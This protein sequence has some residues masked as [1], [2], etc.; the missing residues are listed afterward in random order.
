M[1]AHAD[2]LTVRYRPVLQA[3]WF[4]IYVGWVVV[5]FFVPDW[6]IKLLCLGVQTTGYVMI[7]KEFISQ[8]PILRVTVSKSRV[9]FWVLSW[10]GIQQTETQIGA[11][12]F[13]EEF[14]VKTQN[15]VTINRYHF[16]SNGT[17]IGSLVN[18]PYEWDTGAVQVLL[19]RLSPI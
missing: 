17:P 12:T 11:V 10:S 2:D 18:R 6:A 16:F 8:K 15:D 4:T 9:T 7:L 3:V 19:L 13:T 1:A 5:A 14:M